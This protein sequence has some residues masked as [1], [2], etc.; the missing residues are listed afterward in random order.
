MTRRS[1]GQALA[2]FAMV[3]PLMLLMAIGALDLGRVLWAQDSISN[4]AREGAR[5]A[6]VHGG[7]PE[8]RT[9]GCTLGPGITAAAGCKTVAQIVQEKAVGAGGAVTV[10]VCYGQDCAGDTDATASNL[11]GTPITV[12]VL[13]DLDLITPRLIGLSHFTVQ[14]SSTMLVNN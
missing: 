11:R 8:T 6:I 7:S 14:S 1:R 12:R 13:A 9:D 4:A 3:I 2:E 5:H 10:N